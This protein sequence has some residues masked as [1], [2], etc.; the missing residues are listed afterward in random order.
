[1]VDAKTH[2][3]ITGAFKAEMTEIQ[4]TGQRH[5]QALR[6]LW[7]ISGVNAMICLVK[8]L[9][10]ESAEEAGLKDKWLSC[11][12]CP[13]YDRCESEAKVETE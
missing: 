3:V 5:F 2:T 10:Y 6:S 13:Y 9:Y 4:K 8:L 1:M 12:E 7:L 11:D